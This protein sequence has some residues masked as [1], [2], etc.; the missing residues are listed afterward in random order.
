MEVSLGAT[1]TKD[2]SKARLN[3]LTKLEKCADA[4]L[5]GYSTLL[6]FILYAPSLVLVVLSF[7]KSF[8]MTLPWKGFTVHWY[9]ALFRD[10]DVAI[11]FKN[12]LLVALLTMSISTVLG[13]L[14][15][16]GM[17]RRFRGSKWV[18]QLMLLPLVTP[19]IISGISVFLL[20]THF[21][22]MPS[23][24]GSVLAGHIVFALPYVFLVVYARVQ[25]L[26]PRLEEAAMDLGANETRTFFHVTLPLIMPGVLGGMFF[27]FLLSF[28]EFIRTFFLSGGERTLPMLLWGMLFDVLSPEVAALATV[29]LFTSIGL[30]LIAQYW[31]RR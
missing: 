26:D 4:F 19:G 13:T 24:F 12:S 3:W 1:L 31:M 25:A 22:I 2:V 9:E 17:R 10:A 6:Y 23:L 18:Y 27:S 7:N 20:F 30:L 16:L 29:M 21:S 8:T 5:R 11:S 28:D 14:C 15:A